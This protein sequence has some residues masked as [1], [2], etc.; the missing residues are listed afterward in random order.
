M[1]HRH[2]MENENNRNVDVGVIEMIHQGKGERLPKMKTKYDKVG[3]EV[4]QHSTVTHSVFCTNHLFYF[5]MFI[6]H[7]FSCVLHYLFHVLR[8]A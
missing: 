7:N 8:N 5:F 3:K 6:N 1:Q 4:T 2:R